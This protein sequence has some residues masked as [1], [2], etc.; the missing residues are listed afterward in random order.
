[1]TEE[2]HI[3]FTSCY[4][5]DY[6]FKHIA[7][8]P[9]E[10]AVEWVKKSCP[11]IMMNATGHIK[12]KELTIDD[13]NIDTDANINGWLNKLFVIVGVEYNCWVALYNHDGKFSIRIKEI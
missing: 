5:N 10:A 9:I 7:D 4:I 2:F 8:L 12:A 6:N 13:D 11:E 1:M 3:G